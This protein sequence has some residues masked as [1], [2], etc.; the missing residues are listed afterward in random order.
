MRPVRSALKPFQVN[1]QSTLMQNATQ[2]VQDNSCIESKV[3]IC[4]P[5]VE[6]MGF[7]L[8][9]LLQVKIWIPLLVSWQHTL[10]QF[11]W[12]YIGCGSICDL[13]HPSG[14]SY[15]I[16]LI[17]YSYAQQPKRAVLSFPIALSNSFLSFPMCWHQHSCG[18]LVSWIKKQIWQ[19]TNPKCPK[20]KA[21][22][23]WSHQWDTQGVWDLWFTVGEVVPPDSIPFWVSLLYKKMVVLASHN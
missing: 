9:I 12:Q 7:T 14:H 17:S 15:I 19:K 18:R 8:W 2:S 4:H 6:W 11:L 1:A 23:Q 13:F 20:Y 16:T 3:L 21:F 22:L 5:E 10:T